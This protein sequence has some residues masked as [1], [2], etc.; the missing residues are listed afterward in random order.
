MQDTEI[1]VYRQVVAMTENKIE[2]P[3]MKL[4]AKVRDEISRDLKRTHT[5]ERMKTLEG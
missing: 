4:C 2:G 3:E 5:S 1:S